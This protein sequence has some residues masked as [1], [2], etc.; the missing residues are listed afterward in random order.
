MAAS[1]DM[2]APA[3]NA[4]S[5]VARVLGMLVFVAQNKGEFGVKDVAQAMSLPHSTVHRLLALL[6]DGGFVVH[7]ESRRYRMGPQY[8]RVARMAMEGN[9]IAAAALSPMQA[10]VDACDETVLLGIYHQHSKSL[11]FV[12]RADP[13]KPL[14]YRI[15]MHGVETL[16]WG[17]SGRSILAHLPD[18]A[19]QEV[20]SRN[21]RSPGSG[22]RLVHA[23][24]RA[25]LAAILERGYAISQGQ[26]IE[27]AIAISAPIFGP[28]SAVM[29][30]LTLTI[31]AL[32][33]RAKD[34]LR[35]SAAL[36]REALALSLSLGYQ[37]RVGD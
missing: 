35:F 24:V 30:S 23:E 20:L 21:E 5:T 1:K 17:A 15:R 16:A 3:D 33:F 19:V 29:G 22:K 25:E 26:R 27:G 18:A 32:R 34:E 4:K 36:M 10:I 11:S 8:L 37:P 31:P 7:S 12:A 14:R 9:D 13:P 28:G 6:I 2:D